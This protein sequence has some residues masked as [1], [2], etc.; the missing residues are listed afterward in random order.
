MNIL[1]IGNSFSQDATTYLPQLAKA[2]GVDLTVINLYIGGC[3]LERHYKNIMADAPEYDLQFNGEST[4]VKVSIRQALISRRWDI[5]VTQQ[6]SPKCTNYGTYQP[7][8]DKLAEY[9][10]FYAPTAEL[11]IHQT[12]AY[13]RDSARLHDLMGYS[14]PE[15]MYRDLRDAYAKAAKAVGARIIPSGDAFIRLALRGISH[16]R[17]TFHASKGLGRYTLALTW[18]ETLTGRPAI[19]NALRV[20]D[21][22]ISEEM[23][24]TAQ[25]CA[26]EAVEAMR[27]GTAAI[28]DLPQKIAVFDLDGTLVDS[29]PYFTKGI[30]S[31]AEEAG[32]D[33]DGETLIR[34]LT[35]LGYTKSAEYYV[36]ELGVQDTVE[37]IVGRIEKKLAYEY[38]NNIYLK[39][40]VLDYLKKLRDEGTRLFVLTASP[41]IATDA[42]LKHNGIYDWF[43]QVWSVEDF[44]LSK[45]DTRIFEKVADTIGCEAGEVHYFDDSLIAL[46]NAQAAGYIT[47]GVYD[48]QTPEEVE[49][50]KGLSTTVVMTFENM[51]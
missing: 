45:S 49:T 11:V 1:A 47:Y 38:A 40:G 15:Y 12:W 16:H 27:A 29:M 28:T 14:R 30:L 23:I 37:N 46:R 24:R 33:Y 13:E 4:K 19:G 43:E 26:H 18:Y 9:I 44:K 48:A 2:D 21:E 8:L 34:I 50:M 36:N 17:D 10:R 22:E 6:C 3:S 39:P 32:L 51:K 41:H 25:E 20:F 35:P 31:I 7:Y 5:V 42:C